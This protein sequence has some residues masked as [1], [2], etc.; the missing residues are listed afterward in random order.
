M[1]TITFVTI[2]GTERTEYFENVALAEETY[3]WYER[4]MDLMNLKQIALQTPTYF[5]RKTIEKR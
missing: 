5:Y 2:E 3:K 1:A 4:N